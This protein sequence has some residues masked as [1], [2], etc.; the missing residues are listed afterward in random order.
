MELTTDK[1]MLSEL[2]S[3]GLSSILMNGNMTRSSANGSI[4]QQ[5]WNSTLNINDSTSKPTLDARD[6]AICRTY[7]FIMEAILMGL[8]CIFGFCGNT[9]SMIC[10]SRDKSK[11]AT[12]FLL[13][14]LE[15]ADTFFLFTVIILRVMA[16]TADYF[17]IEQLAPLWPYAGKYIYPFA[18]ISE[19]GTIYLT[20]LVTLNRYVSVCKPYDA[21]SLC[22]V[23]HARNHILLIM[24]FAIIYN[25][26]RFFEYTIT[27][28]PHPEKPGAFIWVAAP[29]DLL[30]NDI[31]Q[32]LYA[33][34]LYSI[35]MFLVPLVMLIFLN[36]N[37]IFALRETKRK[38]AQLLNNT[39][40]H[41]KSEDDI[42]LILIVV[43]LVFVVCQTPALVTQV[44][45]NVLSQEMRGCKSMFFFYERISD[46]LVVCNSSINFIIYCFCS[47]KF[48]QILK[49]L[50]CKEPAESPE[51]KRAAHARAK[52]D[53]PVKE[54]NQYKLVP[55][56]TTENGRTQLTTCNDL[57][58]KL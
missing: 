3:S 32:I 20:L 7:D 41:N 52:N 17:R 47:K 10:L 22:S 39:D 33:N 43:V 9:L 55:N 38:R 51:V 24:A 25:I 16:S 35:V 15:A 19:T 57:D 1:A 8:F 53:R 27:E 4:S 2:G 30:N 36:S 31:Y 12:P 49:S 29:S 21:S 48:R 44:L 42:T 28:Y 46:L 14:S 54:N 18:L 11:T 40:N 6:V 45:S 37:L 5:L 58:T 23:P 26:P 50:I 13:V 34:A 56:E